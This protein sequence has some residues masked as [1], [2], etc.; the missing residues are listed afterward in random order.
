MCSQRFLFPH[1]YRPSE[2]CTIGF[3]IRSNRRIGYYAYDIIMTHFSFFSFVFLYDRKKIIDSAPFQMSKHC[4]SK[5]DEQGKTAILSY[6]VHSCII[7]SAH[8]VYNQ[9]YNRK[10]VFI[11]LPPLAKYLMNG[12]DDLPTGRRPEHRSHSRTDHSRRLLGTAPQWVL[13]VA[14]IGRPQHNHSL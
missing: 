2:V 3:P 11:G 9:T 1:L 5:L 14:D 10:G 4:I 12:C 7:I 6:C 8:F 13:Q